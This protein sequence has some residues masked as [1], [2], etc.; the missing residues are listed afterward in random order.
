MAVVAGDWECEVSGVWDG[1]RFVMVR[2][3]RVGQRPPLSQPAS[4]VASVIVIPPD[5]S[6][7]EWSPNGRVLAL[8]SGFSGL[9]LWNVR[10]GSLVLRARQKERVLSLSWARDSKL[11][12]V[13]T[14]HQIRYL[15][16]DTGGAVYDLQSEDWM[17]CNAASAHGE[18][19]AAS[20]YDGTIALWRGRYPHPP[21]RRL[22]QLLGRATV[23]RSPAL[24]VLGRRSQPVF[25]R[26]TGL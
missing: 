13:G 10:N 24:R 18:R 11:L 7:V 25:H 21:A 17:R 2:R 1:R 20:F 22:I 16:P 26:R 8:N 5:Q 15:R 9:S 6:K 23:C 3:I 14:P 12:F 4:G 19:L